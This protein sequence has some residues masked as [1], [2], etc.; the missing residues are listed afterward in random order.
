MILNE[1]L[2][3]YPQVVILEHI[4]KKETQ[5]GILTLPP[6][7]LLCLPTM[8]VHHDNEFWGDDANEFK[9]ERFSKRASKAMKGRL[10]FFPFSWGLRICIGQNFSMMEAKMAL[11]LILQ[12]FHL[13][14][15]HHMLMLL[16]P[17]LLF[18]HNLVL[19]LF[20]TH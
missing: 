11:A 18:N 9:P 8:L 19:T 17:S 3:L 10:C 6:G 20:Y 4:V 15:P 7:V 5:L 14:Y 16:S 1:V 13:S 12:H 2:R